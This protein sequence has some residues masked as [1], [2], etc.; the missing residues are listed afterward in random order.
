MVG[1]P[2]K[3]C[4]QIQLLKAW[5]VIWNFTGQ[6]WG[7]F[8]KSPACLPASE[9]CRQLRPTFQRVS[10]NWA[11]VAPHWS[12]FWIS[13]SS[14]L[15]CLLFFK[16][17][18]N[19]AGGKRKKGLSGCPVAKTARF[20]HRLQ[21]MRVWSL[22]QELRPHVLNGPAPHPPTP[23]KC[24]WWAEDSQDCFIVCRTSRMWNFFFKVKHSQLV[25]GWELPRVPLLA[26][27]HV[28]WPLHDPGQHRL[29]ISSE[30]TPWF[31]VLAPWRSPMQKWP[32]HPHSMS[33]GNATF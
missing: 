13:T 20:R 27:V 12:S 18:Q 29:L 24:F 17:V 25:M 33:L 11:P 6:A 22:I 30:G 21:G 5:K 15:A 16:T 9:Q 31:A 7:T 8:R 14:V 3:R 4:W 1:Q 32:W 2:K 28:V 10:R 23:P 26:R 19:A